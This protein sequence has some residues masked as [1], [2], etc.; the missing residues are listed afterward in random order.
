[1]PSGHAITSQRVRPLAASPF[2]L[3]LAS[4]VWVGLAIGTGSSI[5]VVRAAAA[6]L[7]LAGLFGLL[8]VS[9]LRMSVRDF[10]ALVI[11]PAEADN[12][13]IID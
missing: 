1:M 5:A 13:K 2:E 9:T 10:A 6:T 12:S 8:S 4:A 3:F 11:D 7:I